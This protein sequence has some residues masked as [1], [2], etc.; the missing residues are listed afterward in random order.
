[1]TQRAMRLTLAGLFA[2][3]MMAAPAAFAEPGKTST[4]GTESNSGG[5]GTKAD[6]NVQNNDASA[7]KDRQKK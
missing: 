5:D 1:M 3:S 2:A 4:G 6:Q 7:D